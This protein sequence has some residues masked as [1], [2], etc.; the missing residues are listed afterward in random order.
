MAKN[1]KA[2]D[3]YEKNIKI[4][5]LEVTQGLCILYNDGKQN[6]KNA[7]HTI[8]LIYKSVHA[9]L[10]ECTNSHED[11]IKGLNQI[12]KDFRGKLKTI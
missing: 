9:S 12:H 2:G 4:K 3:M 7:E 11:W 8:E 10:G 6:L 1:F 5:A